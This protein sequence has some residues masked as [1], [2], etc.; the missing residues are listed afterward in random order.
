M[1]ITETTKTQISNAY[2]ALKAWWSSP[3]TIEQPD[4]ETINRN[5]TYTDVV[6]LCVK[7]HKP[8]ETVYEML[9]LLGY[10]E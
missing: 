5:F 6:F 9:A 4:V 10:E 7:H 2:D 3:D 1:K 8:I